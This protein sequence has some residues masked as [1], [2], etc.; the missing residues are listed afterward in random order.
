MQEQHVSECTRLC[1]ALL[2]LRVARCRRALRPG[3]RATLRRGDVV[4]E[5]D[6][7]RA[8][9]VELRPGQ[10]RG[11]EDEGGV[12]RRPK[13]ATLR[14]DVSFAIPRRRSVASVVG[15][16]AGTLRRRQQLPSSGGKSARRVDSRL[17]GAS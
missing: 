16:I 12:W 13:R 5:R 8:R 11:L 1:Y 7:A 9:V 4:D 17:R 14:R 6:V 3:C 2:R 10:P 15:A